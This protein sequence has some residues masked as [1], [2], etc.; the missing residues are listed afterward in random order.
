MKKSQ[1]I[2]FITPKNQSLVYQKRP[3]NRQ[4]NMHIKLNVLRK[5]SLK[6]PS[7]RT[8]NQKTGHNSLNIAKGNPQRRRMTVD[9]LK[10]ASSF[11]MLKSPQKHP[12]IPRLS[13]I[14]K[15]NQLSKPKIKPIKSRL[16]VK[17]LRVEVDGLPTKKN[18]EEYISQNSPQR[19][20]RD[21]KKREVAKGKNK[22]FSKSVEIN[23]QE[24]S[25]FLHQNQNPS[26]KFIKNY[27]SDVHKSLDQLKDSGF[28][29]KFKEK[30]RI[31]SYKSTMLIGEFWNEK[32]R[33]GVID[34][35]KTCKKPI[36][37]G[38]MAQSITKYVA[39]QFDL[40]DAEVIKKKQK[41]MREKQE[42]QRRLQA[43]RDA[44][45]DQN[46][47]NQLRSNFDSGEGDEETIIDKDDP[48]YNMIDLMV[49]SQ[50]VSR[51][52]TEIDEVIEVFG[53]GQLKNRHDTILYSEEDED[54][55][56]KRIKR[57]K[58]IEILRKRQEQRRRSNVF[59]DGDDLLGDSDTSRYLKNL[60][61]MKHA[62]PVKDE[63]FESEVLVEKGRL[64]SAESGKRVYVNYFRNL[65]PGKAD[66][67]LKELGEE[68]KEDS[69]NSS[70][71]EVSNQERRL[72]N[73]SD[74]TVKN[75]NNTHQPQSARKNMDIKK[76]KAPRKAIHSTRFKKGLTLQ[77]MNNYARN[78]SKEFSKATKKPSYDKYRY[79][80]INKMKEKFRKNYAAEKK[81]LR[82]ILDSCKNFRTDK[83]KRLR[84]SYSI[85]KQFL[86]HSDPLDRKELDKA[87][88]IR[89]YKVMNKD[90]KNSN[91]YGTINFDEYFRLEARK[92]L[93]EDAE[94]IGVRVD[95]FELDKIDDDI[96]K[97][98]IKERLV[99]RLKKVVKMQREKVE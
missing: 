52:T 99:P 41:R 50:F 22:A 60:S 94:K 82:K 70:L 7:D 77:H 78:R 25:T 11:G 42:E 80:S 1:K 51:F 48:H 67:I 46:W 20:K 45:N 54:N 89:E 79:S 56:E 76:P 59:R 71:D 29:K 96:R 33:S 40:D 26:E 4:L 75:S 36:R 34:L 37:A 19:R 44:Y 97:T 98:Q 81:R 23:N 63:R 18:L 87:L 57:L 2:A 35:Y 32:Y 65:E 13:A 38:T 10:L 88:G 85:M 86:Q 93:R 6:T 8:P 39:P 53:E 83:E 69:L 24:L 17:A 64:D 84:S 12:Q 72:L 30:H 68:P 92:E 95:K 27:Y 43:I 74:P 14:G 3:N 9:P 31:D 91:W 15:L 49:K 90:G 55:E 5:S 66:E 58:K 61:Q 16:A 21:Q 28:I 62:E 73:S 47:E